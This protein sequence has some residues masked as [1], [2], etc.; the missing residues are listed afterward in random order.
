MS[1]LAAST[2]LRAFGR[3]LSSLLNSTI[4][5]V[6]V[7]LPVCLAVHELCVTQANAQGTCSANPSELNFPQSGGGPTPVVMTCHGNLQNSPGYSYSIPQGEGP[8]SFQNGGYPT[9]S[10]WGDGNLDCLTDIDYYSY[11][12]WT[13]DHGHYK[14]S[15]VT[16]NNAGIT[17]LGCQIP[18][19]GDV[20]NGLAA[21]NPTDPQGTTNEPI[22]TGNGNYYYQ[23]TDLT[24]SGLVPLRFVRTYNSQDTYAGA[25]GTNWTH[26]YN[27]T[28]GANSTGA[29]VKWGDGH[30]ENYTLSGGVY[31]PAPGVTS[32]LTQNPTSGVWTLTRKDGSQLTFEPFGKL[33]Y[34]RDRNGN[35]TWLSYDPNWN[36]TAVY[37]S[38]PD[39]TLTLSYDSSGRIIQVVDNFS[40]TVSYSYDGNSNLI[41]ETDP[42][43]NVTQYAYDSSNRLTS[44]TLPNKSVLVQNT[45]DSANHVISQPIFP[46]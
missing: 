33:Q 39:A 46:F 43:G 38:I 42:A 40:R 30:G 18:Q 23:H 27:F 15:Y 5:K 12:S 21:P 25:L 3:L 44:I 1:L 29:V 37:A 34:I 6:V 8:R 20:P 11:I 19:P 7:L 14:F 45:Y 36:L 4:F 35:S 28:V 17:G 24:I 22:S 9:D 31:V 32:T 13:D 26:S 16:V 10:F 41:S 2:R